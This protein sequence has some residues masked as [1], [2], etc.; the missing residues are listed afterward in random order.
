MIRNKHGDIPITILVIGV[1]AICALAI[2]SFYFS[3][4]NVRNGFDSLE[5]IEEISIE[6]EKIIFYENAGLSQ[7][8]IK[9]IIEIR[10]DTQG[11]YLFIE[12]NTIRIRYNLP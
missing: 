6:R 4:R 1:L 12:Q 9:E 11:R 10:S 8:E 3:D 7:E 5:L 2:I